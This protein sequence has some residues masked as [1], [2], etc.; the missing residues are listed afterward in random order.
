MKHW[1][2]DLAACAKR[3]GR[4]LPSFCPAARCHPVLVHLSRRMVSLRTTK[5][6]GREIR[7]YPTQSD[8]RTRIFARQSSRRASQW[9]RNHSLSWAVA[10]ARLD[11]ELAGFE[12]RPALGESGGDFVAIDECHAVHRLLRAGNGC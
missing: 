8:F 1:L 11:L 7:L 5:R 12:H 10:V 6:L 2:Q 9:K 3:R 4:T